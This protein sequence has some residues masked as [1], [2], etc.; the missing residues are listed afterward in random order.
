VTSPV[1]SVVVP[2]YQ[3]AQHL[4]DL[5]AALDAQDLPAERY[6]AIL[7]DN[8]STD[9]TAAV[10]TAA[11]G[12]LRM[13]L[14]VLRL[15]ENRGPA[16]ARNAGW[17]AARAPLVA[18]TDDDCLPEQGWL[19]ALAAGL[20]DADVAQGRTEPDPAG[21]AGRG[22]FSHTV[23]IER[24]TERF[25]TCNLGVRRSLLVGLGGFDESFELCYGEDIDL[26]WRALDAGA[27]VA[28]VPDALVRHLVT[29]SSYVAHLRATARREGLVQVVARHPRYRRHLRAG[30]FADPGHPAVLGVLLGLATGHVV[31]RRLGVGPALAVLGAFAAPYVDHRVRVA[32]LWKRR[33]WPVAVPAALAADLVEIAVLARASIRHRT[34]VL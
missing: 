30:L 28:F 19:A 22:P 4:P 8:A 5:L 1:I 34:P 2:T 11:R 21:L 25:E 26:G 33:T 13:D 23:R 24:L 27:S 9:G 31:R 10:L 7:V 18:F 6:E 29:P 14:R 15:I 16:R 12:A 3:R 20:E 32:P 17:R